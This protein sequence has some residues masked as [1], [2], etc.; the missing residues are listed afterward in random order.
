V[1]SPGVAASGAPLHRAKAAVVML[2]GRGA[3]AQDMLSL[4][5]AL[6]LPDIAYLAPQAP[7]STWYPYAFLAPFE[8]N[9]PALSR[10]LAT[11]GSTLGSLAEQ[12]FG[13]QRVVLLGFSQGG[14]LALEYAARN[15]CRYG[16]VVGL[17][18]GLVG[19][20]ATPRN[21]PGSLSGTPVFIG[22]SDSDAH[23]PLARVHES[24]EVLRRL[25]GD[26][27]ER[28]YPGMGH[29][30]NDDEVRHVRRML[31]GLLQANAA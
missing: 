25:G 15:A 26:V 24:T 3:S 5:D 31:A 29:T 14:C 20:P 11:V 8:Q 1:I 4:A 28:I 17:S 10:S 21:Y 7:G 23:I 27:T 9:E 2:H 6:A 19:P 18:A 22:C 16:G 30:I 13:P 12:G